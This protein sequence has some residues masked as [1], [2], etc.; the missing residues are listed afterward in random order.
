MRSTFT[1]RTG[2]PDVLPEVALKSEQIQS[3]QLLKFKQDVLA[4][5]ETLCGCPYL[6]EV[7]MWLKEH[8][9]R[10]VCTLKPPRNVTDTVH[11][12]DEQT[13]V[14]YLLHLDHMRSK[15]RYLKTLKSWST[16]LDVYTAVIF[17]KH[18]I[19]IILQGHEAYIKVCIIDLEN[20]H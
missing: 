19:F 1:I 13:A 15:T 12:V 17:E 16:E 11:D 4:Y 3:D 2:Y 8:V 14:T 20:Q 18:K 10:Y 5:T 9:Q 6:M 7:I